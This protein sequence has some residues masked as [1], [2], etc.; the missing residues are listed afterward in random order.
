M[1][2]E[3]SYSKEEIKRFSIEKQIQDLKRL[4][5]DSDY[6]AIKYAEGLITEQDYEPIKEL[7]QSY[8]DK[9]NELEDSLVDLQND[10]T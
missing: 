2:E 3:L 7:R 10:N 4:L 1:E 9:I 6:K 8:R 5:Q